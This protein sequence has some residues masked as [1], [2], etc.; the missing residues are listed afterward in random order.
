MRAKLLGRTDLN[1]RIQPAAE[2][3]V[4]AEEVSVVSVE[5]AIDDAEISPAAPP[6]EGSVALVE[7]SVEGSAAPM[8]VSEVSPPAEGPPAKKKRS[9]AEDE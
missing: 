4:A 5:I 6:E 2:K 8:E 9:A 7:G 3:I 1:C